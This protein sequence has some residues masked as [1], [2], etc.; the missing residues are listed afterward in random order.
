MATRFFYWSCCLVSDLRA[1]HRNQSNKRKSSFRPLSWSDQLSRPLAATCAPMWGSRLRQIVLS[2]IFSIRILKR[3]N[4][5]LGS[6]MSVISH[7]TRSQLMA[8]LET[9]PSTSRVRKWLTVLN[10]NQRGRRWLIS[11]HNAQGPHRGPCRLPSRKWRDFLR[12][13]CRKAFF[14]Q[15]PA[16]ACTALLSPVDPRANCLRRLKRARI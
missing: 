10:A 4:A 8:M 9:S 13:R 11:T 6:A 7:I 1:L 5:C 2:L 16:L 14:N 15:I 3:A 12:S